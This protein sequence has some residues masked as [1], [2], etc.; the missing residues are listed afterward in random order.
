[1]PYINGYFVMDDTYYTD[2]HFHIPTYDTLRTTSSTHIHPDSP[3]MQLSLTPEDLKL[4]LQLLDEYTQPPQISAELTIH[5][6]L[7]AAQLRLTKDEMEEVMEDQREWMR[8]EKQ[9][10]KEGEHTTMET[11]HW[12]HR[13][14]DARL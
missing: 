4:I 3:A 13:A 8:E 5:V 10:H 6:D 9:R 2:S 14:W 1:M 7:A 12:S 11:Q